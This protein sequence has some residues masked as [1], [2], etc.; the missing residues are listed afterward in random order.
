MSLWSFF[1]DTDFSPRENSILNNYIVIRKYIGAN[2]NPNNLFY[3]DALT[4]GFYCL[5]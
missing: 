5:P 2:N 1:F 3:P 4:S